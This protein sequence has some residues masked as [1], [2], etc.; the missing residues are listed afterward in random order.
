LCGRPG[1]PKSLQ[2]Y[3]STPQKGE[4]NALPKA[5]NEVN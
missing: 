2:I 5:V 1:P 4:N 3:C